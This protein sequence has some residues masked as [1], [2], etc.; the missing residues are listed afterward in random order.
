MKNKLI[1]KLKGIDSNIILIIILVIIIVI[2]LIYNY[3]K[4]SKSKSS[5]SNLYQIPVGFSPNVSQLSS[6]ANIRPRTN[7]CNSNLVEEFQAVSS[8][9][10]VLSLS[11]YTY[12]DNNIN[13]KINIISNSSTK[14]FKPSELSIVVGGDITVETYPSLI[15]IKG[16]T[17]NKIRDIKVSYPYFFI[18]PESKSTGG[19]SNSPVNYGTILNIHDYTDGSEQIIKSS[20]WK[21]G[22]LTKLNNVSVLNTFQCTYIL[23]GKIL[24]E[25][26]SSSWLRRDGSSGVISLPTIVVGT[27]IGIMNDRPISKA[28]GPSTDPLIIYIFNVERY[29]EGNITLNT[30]V[31]NITLKN[32]FFVIP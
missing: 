27:K 20:S 2:I 7:N 15:M 30:T 32:Y 23:A 31:S 10:S 16:A 14:P 12:P 9:S 24:S 5:E 21:A 1:K 4:R 25:I 13:A 22:I 29:E 28:E 3:Y 19:Y 8:E 17:S 11:Y 6:R 26:Y 18:L